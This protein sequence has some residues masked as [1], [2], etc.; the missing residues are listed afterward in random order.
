MIPSRC[1]QLCLARLFVADPT[2][3]ISEADLA[4]REYDL[5]ERRLHWPYYE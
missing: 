4:G 5:A 2:F 1:V 3:S